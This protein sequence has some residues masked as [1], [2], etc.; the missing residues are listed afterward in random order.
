MEESKNVEKG[1]VCEQTFLHGKSACTNKKCKKMHKLDFEKIRR[2]ICCKEFEETGS[3]KRSK[4]RFSHQVPVIL[5][6][7][8]KFIGHVRKER[9]REKEKN[10]NKYSKD[11]AM[12]IANQSNRIA[13]ISTEEDQKSI[14]QH[15]H[16][17][18]SS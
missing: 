1:E 17:I 18:P 8:P 11:R 3:C 7:G 2:G 5:K 9:Q 6:V 4:C 14:N 16:T 10:K 15:Q 13:N 12:K